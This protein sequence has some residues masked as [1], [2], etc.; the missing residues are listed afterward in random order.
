MSPLSPTQLTAVFSLASVSVFA[1]SNSPAGGDA[2]ATGG[3]KGT[4]GIGG[5]MS[6]TGGGG[7]GGEGG[8][9]GTGGQGG[10]TAGASGHG[11]GGNSDGGAA[12]Q[13]GISCGSTSPCTNGQICVHPSCGGGVAVC[14]KLPAGGQCPSDWTYTGNCATGVGPGCIPPPCTPPAPFCAEVP[15]VC[16]GTPSCGCVPASL[17]QQ[18]G[19]TG[20]CQ[21]ANSTEIM[22]GSA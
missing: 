1:C 5:A 18:N 13:A 4:G 7:T 20:S 11:G 6:G 8:A 9:N 17:C 10:A 2:G 22:C 16:S 19:G 3:S 15:A 21:F 12:G 14:E